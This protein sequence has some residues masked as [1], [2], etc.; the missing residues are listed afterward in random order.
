MSDALTAAVH[1]MQG[2]LRYMDTISQNMVNIA[3]PGYRRAIPLAQPFG[4]AMA[5]AQDTAAGPRQPS[6]PSLSSVLDLTPGAL[7]QTGKPWDLAISGDGYFAVE[8]AQ[9]PAYTR[10]GEFRLDA[11]GRLVTGDGHPVQG[12]G[13]DIVLSGSAAQIDH[14]GRI[15]QN[16]ETVGQLKVVRFGPGVALHKT[17]AGLLQAGDPGAGAAVADPELQ[18]GYLENSNVVPMREMVMMMETTRHF[19]AAQKLYQGYD[20]ALSSAIQKLGAF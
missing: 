2:D 16:G 18:V 14:A 12:V 3:T 15:T 1:S 17:G 7:R 8:T 9:G 6:A 19:E 5:A 11:G 4:A 20:E 10:A 13:G